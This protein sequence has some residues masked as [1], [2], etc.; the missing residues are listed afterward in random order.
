[1]AVE[2]ELRTAI[3]VVDIARTIVG[4]VGSHSKPVIKVF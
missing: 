3:K 2:F 4:G 1:V